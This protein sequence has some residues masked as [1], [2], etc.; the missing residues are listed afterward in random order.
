MDCRSVQEKILQFL[1]NE[2]EIDELTEIANHLSECNICS[3]E[4][5]IIAGLIEQLQSW[6]SDEP[7]EDLKARIKSNIKKCCKWFLAFIF[8]NV[9]SG[10][11]ILSER[12][13]VF[14]WAG[15]PK[16]FF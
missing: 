6:K 12:S 14:F 9:K 2:L 10:V 13:S 3:R 5:E 15:S 1:Y 4:R 11:Y 7:C 16:H 8:N